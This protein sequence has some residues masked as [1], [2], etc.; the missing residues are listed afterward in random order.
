M[1]VAPVGPAS[2]TSFTNSRNATA[3]HARPSTATE[4]IASVGGASERQPG[5]GDEARREVV[6]G[7]LDEQ[8]RDA[9]EDR[10]GREQRPAAGAHRAPRSWLTERTAP[11]GSETRALRNAGG[12]SCGATRTRPPRRAASPAVASTSATQKSTPQLAGPSPCASTATTSR[13]TG[14]SGSPPTY[15]GSR[16]R[17]TGPYASAVQPKTE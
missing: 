5:P 13:G 8:V 17:L 15:P 4:A 2:S 6:D 7:D 14:C 3:E 11:A 9:P 12:R 1:S 10:D 16:N